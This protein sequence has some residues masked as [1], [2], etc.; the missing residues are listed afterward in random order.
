MTLSPDSSQTFLSD[1]G[2]TSCPRAASIKYKARFDSHVSAH[3]LAAHYSW[4]PFGHRETSF[5]FLEISFYPG[6]FSHADATE[7]F[8]RVPYLGGRLKIVEFF[9]HTAHR[10][11]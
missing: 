9:N 3:T 1:L 4:R 11:K 8:L 2:A 5:M 10:Q 7:G 6:E